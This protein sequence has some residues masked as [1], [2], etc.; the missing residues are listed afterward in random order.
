MLFE[1]AAD[2]GRGNRLLE[3]GFQ[4]AHLREGHE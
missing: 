2:L 3:T 4:D 1:D